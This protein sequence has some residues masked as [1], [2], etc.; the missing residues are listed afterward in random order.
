MKKQILAAAAFAISALYFAP[1]QADTLPD[2]SIRW[3]V[4]YPAG[5]GSDF[6]A[7]TISEGLSQVIKQPIVIDNKPG[8]N[9]AIAAVDTARSNPDGYTVLSADNGTLTFNPRSEERRVGKECVRTCSSR[10]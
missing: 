8:G 3:I 1:V 6:L 7:R 2:K 9:T 4:P 10:W 5:G